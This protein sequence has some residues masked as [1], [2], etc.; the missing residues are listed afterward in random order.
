MK[1]VLVAGSTGY[2][3][4]YVVRELKKQGYWVRALARN[5]KKLDEIKDSIDEIFVGEVTKPETLNGVCKGI[6]VL[7][8]SIGITRQKDGLTYHDVDYQGNKNLLDEAL[9]SGVSK[10]IYVSALNDEKMPNIKAVESKIQ[11]VKDLK[12][13]GMEY[14]IICPSAF[15]S[16]MR[17]FLSLAKSGMGFLLGDGQTKIN[18][19]D[20]ADLAEVC[21]GAINGK[22]TQ[23]EVGGPEIMTSREMLEM[24]FHALGKEPNIISVPLWIGEAAS[25]VLKLFAPENIYSPVEFAVAAMGMDMVGK[26][27]GKKRLADF[28][29]EEVEKTASA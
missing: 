1:K 7:F 23:I 19:I 9:K 29:K 12:N 6:D 18:P 15:F 10:F 17:E 22:E 13:S 21:V 16:D 3:G 26:P 25:G 2:L 8:S 27:Y 14:A 24:S 28:F 11:F 5:P 20:G 4:Q